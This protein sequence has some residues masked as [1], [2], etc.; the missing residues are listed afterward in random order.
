[1]AED[2]TMRE[3]L[4]S[5]AETVTRVRNTDSGVIGLN[6]TADLDYYEVKSYSVQANFSDHSSQVP[7]AFTIIF[8]ETTNGRNGVFWK[9]R[10]P[11]AI[12]AITNL[13]DKA[14]AAGKKVYYNYKCDQLSIGREPLC[15]L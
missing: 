13:L 12:E 3:R 8:S 10:S 1:M 5:V 9:N 4:T 15:G 2:Q 7:T 11:E 14:F 6:L